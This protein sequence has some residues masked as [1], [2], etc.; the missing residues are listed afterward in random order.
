[1]SDLLACAIT[2]KQ[3]VAFFS[4]DFVG[5]RQQEAR[6]PEHIYPIIYFCGSLSSREIYL[7]STHL[8]KKQPFF[9]GG[10]TPLHF[11]SLGMRIT[12]ALFVEKISPEGSL[13]GV[14]HMYLGAE[15]GRVEPGVRWFSLAW[16]IISGLLNIAFP[17]KV[18]FPTGKDRLPTFQ[19]PFF[20][21]DM[22]NFRGVFRGCVSFVSLPEPDTWVS[23]SL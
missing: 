10:T 19:P 18:A 20:R 17:W 12:M 11:L 14:R 15:R 16:R 6:Y 21:G 13:V 5:S 1:M 4:T 2:T 7:L 9:Q 3:L 23:W 8:K 22:L